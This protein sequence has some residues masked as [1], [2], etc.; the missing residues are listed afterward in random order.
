MPKKKRKG[1]EA[2]RVKCP[3]PS[4]EI[5]ALIGEQE[6]WKMEKLKKKE[7][8]QLPTLDHSVASYNVKGSYGEPIHL[9]PRGI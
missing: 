4:W 1:I 7:T 5:D 8:T 9:A 2:Q 3:T 6:Q